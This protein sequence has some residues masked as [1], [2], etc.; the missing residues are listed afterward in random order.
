MG[1]DNEEFLKAVYIIRQAG[2][3]GSGIFGIAR[4]VKQGVVGPAYDAGM[5]PTQDTYRQ[6]ILKVQLFI[7][8]HLD[9][10]LALERLARVAHFSPF[11]FHRIFTALV[12]ESVHEYVRRLRLERG[13][14]HL[15][16]PHRDIPPIALD[17]GYQ[18]HEAFTRAFKQMFGVSPS[19]FRSERREIP[20]IRSLKE[21]DMT[22]TEKTREVQ[23][24]NLSPFRVAFIRKTGPYNDVGP[25]FERLFGW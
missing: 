9:E 22:T 8:E 19:R 18:A 11:H 7:Q 17:A 16:K 4:S 15:R 21:D 1:G 3:L 10:D 20:Q 24:R 5:N 13:A 12:G 25:T 14:S 23:I 2:I 6:R